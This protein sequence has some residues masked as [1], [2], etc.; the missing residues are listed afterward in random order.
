MTHDNAWSGDARGQDPVASS[1]SPT[2]LDP[3]SEFKPVEPGGETTS[4]ATLLIEAYALMW[5]VVF[6]FIWM[7]WRRQKSID[8][9]IDDLRAA[10]AKARA[11]GG[12]A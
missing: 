3:T 4:G 6:V 5:L 2:A 11:E 1:Q 12:G 9:R 7:S 8:Q 10:I